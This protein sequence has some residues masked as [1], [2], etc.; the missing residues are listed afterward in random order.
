MQA[1]KLAVLGVAMLLAAGASATELSRF[2]GHYEG[3]AVAGGDEADELQL[4]DL[5]VD[6]RPHGKRG[7]TVAWT[8]VIRKPDGRL[9][10]TDASVDFEPAPRDGVYGSAMR[11]NMFGQPV[12]LDPLAGEPFVWATLSGDLLVV[13]SLIITEDGGYEMQSYE[14]TLTTEGMRLRFVRVRDGRPLRTVEGELHR[15]ARG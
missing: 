15:Q 13:H 7:F 14:R 10:R 3:I 2:F 12:P 9:K 1:I 5:T 4:R 6:I 8:T 11:K